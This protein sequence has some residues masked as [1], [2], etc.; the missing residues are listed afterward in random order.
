LNEQPKIQKAVS[1]AQSVYFHVS[2][3][4]HQMQTN[5]SSR[6]SKITQI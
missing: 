1:I 5:F 3:L 2:E 4:S 6:K